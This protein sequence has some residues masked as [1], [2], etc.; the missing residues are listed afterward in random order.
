MSMFILYARDNF[1]RDFKSKSPDRFSSFRLTI[2]GVQSSL[3]CV[4]KVVQVSGVVKVGF[5][6]ELTSLIA[7]IE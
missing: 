7:H 5:V 4:V 1:N 2:C 6:S 3:E